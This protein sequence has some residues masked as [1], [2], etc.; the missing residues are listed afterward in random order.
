MD[1]QHQGL[2]GKE[3]Y[4]V[5]WS[6]IN[7]YE[8]KPP[9]VHKKHFQ[10]LSDNFHQNGFCTISN[11][12]SKLRMYGLLKSKIGTESYLTIITNPDIR[13][14]DT[15]FMLSNHKL[16]IETGRHKNIPKELCLCPFFI[17]SVEP[18]IHFLCSLLLS[19]F[20]GGKGNYGLSQPKQ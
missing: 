2:P 20:L 10:R 7:P 6:Y 9:F 15:K 11:P 13:L 12:Q 17:N 4:D 5:V 18:E 3:W 19:D 16:N 14:T 1:Q 8:N